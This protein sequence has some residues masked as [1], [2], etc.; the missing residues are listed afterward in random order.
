MIFQ[1]YKKLFSIFSKNFDKTFVFLCNFPFFGWKKFFPRKIF[2]GLAHI[3]RRTP[4]YRVLITKPHFSIK[5]SKNF[6]FFFSLGVKYL[7]DFDKMAFWVSCVQVSWLRRQ[8]DG[9]KM[10]LLTVGQQ[11]Y[12]GDMRYTVDFQYPDNWRLQIKNVNSSDEGQYE[13]QISTHPP[14]FIHVN[15]H[16]NG[17][18]AFDANIILTNIHTTFIMHLFFYR[19]FFFIYEIFRRMRVKWF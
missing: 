3:Y 13:C 19:N 14:K 5:L 11:T 2:P 12:T 6:K 16:V 1:F 10:N 4:I 9:Q 17:I 18:R 7:P 8:N 15:L